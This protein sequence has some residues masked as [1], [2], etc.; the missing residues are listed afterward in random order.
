METPKPRYFNMGPSAHHNLMKKMSTSRHIIIN[1]RTHEINILKKFLEIY[2]PNQGTSKGSVI[3]MASE[4]SNRFW[5]FTY[6]VGATGL[7]LSILYPT[8][9]SIIRQERTVSDI[10]ALREFTSPV[11]D[12]YGGYVPPKQRCKLYVM[13]EGK[14]AGIYH[15]GEGR[16]S[17]GKCW[18]A[19]Q[20]NPTSADR[21]SAEVPREG[22]FL[23][24]QAWWNC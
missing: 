15:K 14:E 10:W 9:P 5:C 12:S 13:A 2:N 21:S 6:N 19:V 22:E 18:G 8:K 17:P 16:K 7:Q 3:R 11:W 4:S 1:L 20:N 23:E 24:W